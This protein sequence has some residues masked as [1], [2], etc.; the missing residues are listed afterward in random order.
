M[1][2]LLLRAGADPYFGGVDMPSPI[3]KAVEKASLGILPVLVR[4]KVDLNQ[5]ADSLSLLE[6][7]IK[8]QRIDWVNGLIDEGAEINALGEDGK[9]AL[10]HA[11]EQN[12]TQVV[13]LLLEADANVSIKSKNGKTALEMAEEM[14]DRE[15]IVL[16]L[17]NK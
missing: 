15:E 16:L 5:D 11:V 7:A 6:W 9:T 2:D 3:V 4:N 1:F 17:N 8:Y 14:G 13:N 10:M 12:S